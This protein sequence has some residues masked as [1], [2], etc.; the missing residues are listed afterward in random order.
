MFISLFGVTAYLHAAN[1]CNETRKLSCTVKDNGTRYSAAC[2]VNGFEVTTT[3]ANRAAGFGIVI[4]SGAHPCALARSLLA[5]GLLGLSRRQ[6]YTVKL[7]K[8]E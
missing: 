7:C 3:A 6:G 2:I 1:W 5:L 8:T 4:S